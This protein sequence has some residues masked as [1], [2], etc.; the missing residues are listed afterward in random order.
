MFL[1]T[2]VIKSPSGV[3]I[4]LEHVIVINRIVLILDV[5]PAVIATTFYGL[6]RERHNYGNGPSKSRPV[7]WCS[8]SW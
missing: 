7:V 3:R 2:F 4:L 6:E 1:F 5:L 8:W